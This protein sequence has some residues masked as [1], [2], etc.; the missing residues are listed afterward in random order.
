M[1]QFKATIFALA[2]IMGSCANDADEPVPFLYYGYEECNLNATIFRSIAGKDKTIIGFTP[3][4]RGESIAFTL[5]KSY[6]ADPN[7]GDTIATIQYGK[8]WCTRNNGYNN[9]GQDYAYLQHGEDGYLIKDRTYD[10]YVY[11]YFTPIKSTYKYVDLITDSIKFKGIWIRENVDKMSFDEDT[12]LFLGRIADYKG[13]TDKV[14]KNNL[15]NIKNGVSK[16]SDNKIFDF[17][18]YLSYML[19]IKNQSP[20]KYEEEMRTILEKGGFKVTM[21]NGENETATMNVSVGEKTYTIELGNAKTG[22]TFEVAIQ[23]AK[24]GITIYLGTTVVLQEKTDLSFLKNY[25]GEDLIVRNK[26]YSIDYLKVFDRPIYNKELEKCY[27]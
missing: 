2:I 15:Q 5:D 18:S 25:N 6:L 17:D 23:L 22:Q 8:S 4:E 9:V 12:E 3:A 13:G 14:R 16:A 11:L 21:Q 19:V 20:K 7:T 1:K 26:Y 27:H 24:D 10:Y